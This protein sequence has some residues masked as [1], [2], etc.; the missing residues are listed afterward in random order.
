M[1]QSQGLMNF[2]SKDPE[3]IILEM[4]RLRQRALLGENIELPLVTL[5]LWPDGN[6]ASGFIIDIKTEKDVKHVAIQLGGYQT[7]G[8]MFY[9]YLGAIR[10]VVVHDIEK[11]EYLLAEVTAGTKMNKAPSITKL[12]IRKSLDEESKKISAT[13]GSQLSYTLQ[14][15]L[16]EGAVP[17]F[18]IRNLIVDVTMCLKELAQTAIGKEAV[19]DGI[20]KVSFVKNDSDFSVTRHGKE[21][22]VSGKF[23]KSFTTSEGRWALKDKLEA[24]L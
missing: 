12:D 20:S 5:M 7:T 18:V 22:V 15:E 21:L 23:D 3:E 19:K 4:Y 2:S 17:L 14:G 6:K 8:D 10:G 9:A 16:P 11:Y 24:L 1:S 13:T